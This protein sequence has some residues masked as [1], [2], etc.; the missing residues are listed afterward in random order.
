VE[1][2][3]TDETAR[4][5]N[6]ELNLTFKRQVVVTV[7]TISIE[8]YH[9]ATVE[10]TPAKYKTLVIETENRFKTLSSLPL[11]KKRRLHIDETQLGLPLS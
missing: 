5:C 7:E 1:L 8:P 2:K 10:N 3:K 4:N 6:Y 9:L 11:L